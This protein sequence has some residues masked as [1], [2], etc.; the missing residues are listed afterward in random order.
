MKP[1]KSLKLSLY[2]RNVCQYCSRVIGAVN[3]LQA[4]VEGKNIWDD[5]QA[6]SE[7]QTATGRLTVPVLKIE[8]DDG[9]IAWLPESQ[10]IVDYLT[11]VAAQNARIT[12]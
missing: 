11:K 8:S 2:Y 12:T 5:K 6:M 7:L 10:D 1:Q 3:Y 9:E 4:E